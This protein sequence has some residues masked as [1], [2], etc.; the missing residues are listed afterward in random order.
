MKL[1]MVKVSFLG[2]SL[3]L[4]DVLMKWVSLGSLEFMEMCLFFS[5]FCLSLSYQVM[6]F[7]GPAPCLMGF[8]AKFDPIMQRIIH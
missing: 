4:Y 3:G 1:E 2:E 7:G 5:D 6:G 8:Y